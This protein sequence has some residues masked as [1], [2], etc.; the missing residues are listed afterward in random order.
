M[1]PKLRGLEY[2]IL[3]HHSRFNYTEMKSLMPKDAVFVTILRDPVRQFESLYGYYD[4][5]S[6]YGV[7]INDLKSYHGVGINDIVDISPKVRNLKVRSLKVR[8]LNVE[9]SKRAHGKFGFNQ[10]LFD[11]GFDATN[12]HVDD[13]DEYIHQLD[14]QFH[15][16]M[17]ADFMTESLVLLK[18]LLNWDYDDIAVFK[19]NARKKSHELTQEAG[20]VIRSLNWAD[21]RLYQFFLDKFEQKVRHFGVGKMN[22]EKDHLLKVLQHWEDRCLNEDPQ[23]EDKETCRLMTEKELVFTDMLRQRQSHLVL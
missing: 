20:E 21:M 8:N 2:N 15:L 22:R 17:I 5:K 19:V 23:E 3:A 12:K 13:V 9:P 18:S 10:M 11:L 6:Y 14:K 16:V 7:G 4:L 1:I